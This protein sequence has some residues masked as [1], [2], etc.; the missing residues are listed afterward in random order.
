MLTL[1]PS[2]QKAIRRFIKGS[3][4]AVAGLRIAV[5]GGGCSGLQYSMS[6]VDEK[7]AEDVEVAC[8]A[9]TVFVDALSAPLLRGLVVDF[10]DGI[11]ASGFK[12]QNPNAAHSCGCGNSFT[13]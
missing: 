4:N 8:G 3:D 13:A 5:N 7:E 1:T 9:V 2:A 10:V 11:D 6:L 12:F